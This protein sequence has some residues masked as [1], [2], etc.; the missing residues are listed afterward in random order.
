MSKDY[1]LLSLG[2]LL[3]IVTL[4]LALLGANLITEVE[5]F[6]LVVAFYGVW[7]MVLA[8]I[9]TK[10][11]EKY[12][13]G[14]YSTLVWGILLTVVGGAWFLNLKGANIF[15]TIALLLGV[16]GILALASA[17]PSIRRK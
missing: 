8:G 4:L 13:R 16:V 10:R 14:A 15:F 5:V 12:G 17:L 6:A 11:P 2:A 1:G 9:R 7:M 3:I